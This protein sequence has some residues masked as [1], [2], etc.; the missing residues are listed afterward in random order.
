MFFYLGNRVYQK[1]IC[2]KF[3]EVSDTALLPTTTTEELIELV[4]YVGKTEAEIL[5]DLQ[6]NQAVSNLSVNHCCCVTME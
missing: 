4:T 6:V 5:P 2:R 3:D 1:E